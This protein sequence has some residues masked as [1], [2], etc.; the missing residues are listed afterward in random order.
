MLKIE[1]LIYAIVWMM[2]TSFYLSAVYIPTLDINTFHIISGL[3]L[4]CNN[5]LNLS[6]M[7][8]LL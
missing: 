5:L 8:T 2:N 7:K 6:Q 3:D 1:N 4:I